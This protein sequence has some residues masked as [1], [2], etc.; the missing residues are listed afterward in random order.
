MSA[1]CKNPFLIKKF[2]VANVF[3]EAQSTQH[4]HEAL[5]R[6]IYFISFN[7]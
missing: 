2:L 7:P 4:Y 3:T 1:V 6:E 5:C